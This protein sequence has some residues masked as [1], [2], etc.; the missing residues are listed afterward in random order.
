MFHVRCLPLLFTQHRLDMRNFCTTM[1]FCLLSSLTTQAQTDITPVNILATTWSKKYQL[2]EEQQVKAL[3][4][5][6]DKL[7]Q[8][9]SISALMTSNPKKYYAKL[10]DI[11]ELT[12]KSLKNILN[13]EEQVKTYNDTLADTAKK[14]AT[15]QQQLQKQGASKAQIK[16][17]L[18]RIYAE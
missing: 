10:N 2:D 6:E 18:V 1:L 16:Q 4:I 3:K 7:A 8:I 13:R 11:Q 12:L 9:E 15:V 17:E 14:R 5:A